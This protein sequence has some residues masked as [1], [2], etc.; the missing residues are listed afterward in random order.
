MMDKEVPKRNKFF[1]KDD[2]TREQRATILG[3]L[4][5][6]AAYELGQNG[7]YC[8]DEQVDEFLD[9]CGMPKKTNEPWYLII[10]ESL[11]DMSEIAIK[12]AIKKYFVDTPKDLKL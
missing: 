8:T 5:P 12:E 6:L 11:K 7:C 2:L 4:Q 1:D 10:H 9:M 3:I